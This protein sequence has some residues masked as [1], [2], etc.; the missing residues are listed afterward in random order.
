[1]PSNSDYKLKSLLP[2]TIQQKYTKPE[3]DGKKIFREFVEKASSPQYKDDKYWNVLRSKLTPT[4]F[5][6]V[7]AMF[8]R[9]QV[10]AG[11]KK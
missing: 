6:D 4:K 3:K 11:I 9:W 10:L 5:K 2:K 1:M 8:N 7:D